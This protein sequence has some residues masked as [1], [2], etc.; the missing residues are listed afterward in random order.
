MW[1]E[2]C[3]WVE[4]MFSLTS[5]QED[6]EV[7]LVVLWCDGNDP[8]FNHSRQ[9]WADKTGQNL[10]AGNDPARFIQSDELRYFLRSVE[11]NAPWIRYVWLVTNGQTPSWL[12]SSHPKLK[13]VSHQD[14]MPKDALPTF[15]ASAIEAALFKIP[16]LAEHFLLANDDTFIWR[17]IKKSFFFPQQGHVYNFYKES[18]WTKTSPF[19]MYQCMLIYTQQLVKKSFPQANTVLE[20]HHNI[21]GYLK[22]VCRKTCKFF[23]AEFAKTQRNRFREEAQIH[24]WIF[25]AMSVIEK[26]GEWKPI[27][28][29]W[30]KKRISVVKELWQDYA[31]QI[32]RENPFL[33]CLNDSERCTNK[34]RQDL[35]VFLKSAFPTPSSFEKP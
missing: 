3:I 6:F 2:K 9:T 26:K 8:T 14:F 17:K 13:L 28:T 21:D 23:P 16:H 33:V 30:F 31:R 1:L 29:Y 35:T 25:A 34:Q 27:K 22:S 11:K 15:N 18:S 4:Q 19:N 24:R 32:R 20:P 12:V 10:R 7:D 5:K